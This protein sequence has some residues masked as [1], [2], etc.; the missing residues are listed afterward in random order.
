MGTR[1]TPAVALHFYN[2][3]AAHSSLIS[4]ARLVRHIRCVTQYLKSD[5]ENPMPRAAKV[6]AKQPTQ[7]G[8]Y[9]KSGTAVAPKEP[10]EAATPRKRRPRGAVPLSQLTASQRYALAREDAYF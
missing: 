7:R 8:F 3:V 10:K 1:S 6:T 2:G 4:V 9:K 5:Q